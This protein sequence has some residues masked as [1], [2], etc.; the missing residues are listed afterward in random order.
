MNKRKFVDDNVG[1]D[2]I[3]GRQIR[4]NKVEILPKPGKDYAELVLFG[5]MHYGAQ[6]CD[7]ARAKRMLDYCLLNKIHIH[8]MGDLMES[9]TRYS[10]GAGVYEQFSPQKQ[11][12]GII[13]ML[14][15]LA[16]V[17]LITGTHSGNHEDR[18]YKETG[19]DVMKMIAKGLNIKYLRGACW[20]LITVGK[21]K[22]LMYSLHGSSGSRYVY[23][24]LKSLVDI[25]HNF[26]ADIIAMGHVHELADT[27]IVVQKVSLRSKTVVEYKKFLVVTGHYLSYDGSYAQN[28]GMPIGKE[29]SPK[30]KLFA[31]KHDIHISY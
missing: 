4:L 17:G 29:G 2:K 8:L 3:P 24:K 12:D 6:N 31:N 1:K 11:L 10:V 5:D 18:I 28:K 25:S 23:T 9:A 19:I 20:N 27:S 21:E 30:L 26:D 16:E 15:P 22:Y 14:R 7:V 13:D